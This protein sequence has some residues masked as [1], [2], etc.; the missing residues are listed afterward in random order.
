MQC[1]NIARG[2][3]FAE[4][5]LQF[6]ED[7]WDDNEFSFDKVHDDDVVCVPQEANVREW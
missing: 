5:P 1:G 2:P 6:E 3:G 7:S 4:E